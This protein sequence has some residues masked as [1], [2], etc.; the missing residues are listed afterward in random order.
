MRASAMIM[1]DYCN[2]RPEKLIAKIEA[3]LIQR[4][5]GQKLFRIRWRI[6]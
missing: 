4:K 5:T 6:V 2:P 3:E 1:N